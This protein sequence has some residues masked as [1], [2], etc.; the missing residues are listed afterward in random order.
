MTLAAGTRLGAYEVL[1]AL[2]AG[3][4]G[5]VYRARDT[6]LQRDVAIKILPALFAT[7]PDRL[8]RFEREATALAS[9]NHSHIAQI[10]GIEVSEGV[11]ALVMELVEGEDLSAQIARGP[12]ALDEAIPIARQVAEALEAAHE[13]GIIHRDLKPANIKV[14]PDGTVKV[15]DFGLAKALDPAGASNPGVLMNSPTFTNPALTQMGLVLGTAAYMAPEQ[16]KG[17]AVDRRVDI[18]A[19][20]VVLY[21]MLTGRLPFAGEGIS[22]IVAAIIKDE[23]AW[24]ALPADV[25]PSVRRLLRHCLEKDPKRRLSSIADARF[26]LEELQDGSPAPARHRRA[27][28]PFVLAAGLAGA[29][30]GALGVYGLRQPDASELPVIRAVLPLEDLAASR[31]IGK[32]DATMALSPDGRLLAFVNEQRSAILLHD[33]STGRSR[34]LVQGGELGAPFF[35]P[36]GRSLGYIAGVGGSIRT[37]VWGSLKTVPITGGAATNLADDITG[38]KGASWGDDGWIYYSPS[39]AFGLW[40]VRADGGAPEKLTEPDAAAGEK[41]HRLPFVLP[42]SRGVLF[43]VGTS[44]ITSFDDARIEVL[45]LDDR[46]RHPLVEGGTAPRYLP[47]GHLQYQRGGQLLAMPFDLRRL[48]V[49][50]VPVAVADGVDYFAP[51]GSSYDSVSSNGTIVFVPRNPAPLVNTLIA[52][53]DRGQA[54]RLADAPFHPSSGK[55]SPD[56]RRIAV[57]PDG[58][59]QQI[60]ILDFVRN[61]FQRVTFEWDN[62]SPLWVPDGSRLVFRSNTGGGLRRLHWQPADGTGVPEALSTSPRDEIPTSIHGN[63]LLY[64]DVD[65]GTRTDIWIMSLDDRTSRPFVQTRFDE[66]GA[67]FSPDGRWV[68]YQSNQ[69]GNWEIYVQAVSGAGGRLQASQDGGVRA[70]WHPGGRSLTFLRGHD[71]MRVSFDTRGAELGLPVRL[72]ALAPEDLLLDVLPDGR[73]VVLRRAEM[74]PT[75]SLTILTNWFG[76]VR[77]A[78]GANR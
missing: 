69:S 52:F 43:V 18:W 78:L 11:H 12:M 37:A 58:A 71:V 39:P 77:D 10:Y 67:Q 53:D 15:L 38:L 63:Q 72:F 4:M 50:G 70:L 65:P 41:T 7:D 16:A 26:D 73:L 59:T 66:G 75:R 74:A 54:T 22:E 76:H 32:D 1:G 25:P 62:A 19:F 45:K 49:S 27:A 24:G 61:T 9:L 13:A 46:T 35:S 2:G 17:K 36:D 47:S 28:W 64:E 29:V 42:G 55:V 44:R 8:M 20:G 68:A 48:E 21:E 3:G 23:I 34:P 31:L 33:L 6:R 56:G 60:A 14:R 5:E 51:S 57:D 30:L 40:R